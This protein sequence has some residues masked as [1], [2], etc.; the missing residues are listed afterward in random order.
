MI[1]R[2]LDVTK[3]GSS[4]ESGTWFQNMK[5]FSFGAWDDGRWESYSMKGYRDLDRYDYWEA[6]PIEFLQEILVDLFRR[7][8]S[9]KPF[10][11][12]LNQAGYGVMGDLRE[13]VLAGCMALRI[14][15]D[16]RSMFGSCAQPGH[17]RV[18][19]RSLVPCIP[20][21]RLPESVTLAI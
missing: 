19:S 5:T 18:F 3:S 1:R 12:Y 14:E 16:L 9:P 10:D 11:M 20:R 15:H 21:H 4:S 13:S 17:S 7:V 6:Y 2:L 8:S